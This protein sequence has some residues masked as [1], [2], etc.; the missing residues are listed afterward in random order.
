[1][2]YCRRRCCRTRQPSSNANE[3]LVALPFSLSMEES[4]LSLCGT[5]PTDRPGLIINYALSRR[6]RRSR[7][8]S[9][10]ILIP[11]IYP[12]KSSRGLL[13]QHPRIPDCAASSPPP[14]RV[15]VS[16]FICICDGL[17]GIV[18]KRTRFMSDWRKS[19][20]QNRERV[21]RFT[22]DEIFAG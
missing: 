9:S 16:F 18:Y 12:R 17:E 19:I 15:K 11:W 14:L 8:N 3:G 10:R 20:T 6:R 1:M 7:R 21:C 5:L 4:S 13:I 2:G 22:F